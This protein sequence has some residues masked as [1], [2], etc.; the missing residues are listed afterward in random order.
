MIVSLD[1]KERNVLIVG[2]GRQGKRIAQSYEREGARVVYK[3]LDFKW[4][5]VEGMDLVVACT[6][7]PDFN[8]ALVEYVNERR[9]F[10]QSVDLDEKASLHRMHSL[11]LDRFSLA[12]STKGAFPMFY[13]AFDPWIE[14]EFRAN[15][16]RRL[17]D[18][19]L[20]RPHLIGDKKA[21]AY[22]LELSKEQ[23]D[24][25]VRLLDKKKGIVVLFAKSSVDLSCLQKHLREDMAAFY[26]EEKFEELFSVC[27]LLSISLVVQPMFLFEGYLYYQCLKLPV[28]CLPLLFDE[29]LWRRIVAPFDEANAIFVLHPTRDHAFQKKI[30]HFVQKGQVCECVDPLPLKRNQINVVVP[31]FML[32]GKHVQDL[33]R[34]VEKAR[35]KGLR[36]VVPFWCLFELEIVQDRLREVDA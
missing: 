30:E 22:L 26:M 9:I 17:L 18:L 27:R 5:D 15:W 10:S 36:V 8:H 21:L 24:W 29:K 11:D 4:S 23:L 14:N 12:Y 16:E 33:K 35:K 28:S 2:W 20:L 19:S 1:W 3:D 31:L 34:K 25:L 32:E 6:S 13:R 7:D